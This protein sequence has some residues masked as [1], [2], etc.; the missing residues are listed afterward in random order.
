MEA[1]KFRSFV[2]MDAWCFSSRK[3]G[4]FTKRKNGEAF[5]VELFRQ[6]PKCDARVQAVVQI[7]RIDFHEG[8]L[9][10]FFLE[11]IFSCRPLPPP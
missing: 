10:N 2:V 3:T 6:A 1:A 4:H 5:V 11:K 9:Q 7:G 8:V